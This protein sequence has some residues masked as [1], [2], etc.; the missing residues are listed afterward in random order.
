MNN[1]NKKKRHCCSKIAKRAQKIKT[2]TVH[3]KNRKSRFKSGN[4][5]INIVFCFVIIKNLIDVFS[6]EQ[7][8]AQ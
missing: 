5:I 6:S 3:I 4:F 8:S 1:L 2:H 7:E